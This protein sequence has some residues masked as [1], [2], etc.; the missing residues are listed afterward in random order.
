MYLYWY[1]NTLKSHVHNF[2]NRNSYYSYNDYNVTLVLAKT[3]ID[4]KY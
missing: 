4:N 3:K 2:N 1:L